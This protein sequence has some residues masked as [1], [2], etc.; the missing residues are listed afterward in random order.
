MLKKVS[1][2]LGVLLLSFILG[3]VFMF[4]GMNIGGNYFANYEMFGVRGYEATGYLGFIFGI[5]VGLV[6]SV[7]L[8][9]LIST[10]RK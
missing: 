4:L 2:I 7:T 9:Y 6:F 5:V 10:K 8:L 1:V 3:I